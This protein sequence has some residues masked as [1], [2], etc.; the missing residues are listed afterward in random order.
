MF[1]SSSC[2][3]TGIPSCP[4]TFLCQKNANMLIRPHRACRECWGCQSE[5]EQSP[6]AECFPRCHFLI[7]S[8]VFECRSLEE[9]KHTEIVLG[10]VHHSLMTLT[11]SHLTYR[12]QIDWDAVL[13]NTPVW[14]RNAC[15]LRTYTAQSHQPEHSQ[16]TCL[17]FFFTDFTNT[18]WQVNLM[19]LT[20]KTTYFSK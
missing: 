4:V 19:L 1:T 5:H 14:T 12:V 13:K 20:F 7:P 6:H 8:S 18:I 16:I 9:L 3:S 10:S 11:S 15:R 2:I 17:I